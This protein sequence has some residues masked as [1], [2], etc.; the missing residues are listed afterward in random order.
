MH[1]RSAWSLASQ[2]A[3][4]APGPGPLGSSPAEEK[5]QPASRPANQIRRMT[6]PSHAGDQPPTKTSLHYLTQS[7]IVKANLF[8]AVAPVAECAT[9]AH[10]E[11]VSPVVRSSCACERRTA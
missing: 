5:P 3:L 2:R 7:G 6:R 4:A 1:N 8:V 10:G 11:P 9:I